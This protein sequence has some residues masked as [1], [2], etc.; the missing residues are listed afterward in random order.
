MLHLCNVVE[1]QGTDWNSGT[2]GAI[3]TDIIPTLKLELAL[4]RSKGFAQ[5]TEGF[6][7]TSKFL[8]FLWYV[9]KQNCYG[10]SQTYEITQNIFTS[11]TLDFALARQF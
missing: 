2:F 5:N 6:V 1:E 10:N 11:S 9:W 3:T 8:V 7:R 4:K